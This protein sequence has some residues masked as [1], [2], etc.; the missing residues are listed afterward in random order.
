LKVEVVPTEDWHKMTGVP[1]LP[2]RR[3]RPSPM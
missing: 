3:S 1:T 2:G